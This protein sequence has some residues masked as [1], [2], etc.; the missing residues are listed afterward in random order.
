MSLVLASSD[1][2]RIRVRTTGAVPPGEHEAVFIDDE[3]VPMDEFC[4]MVKE[5]VGGNMALQA[6]PYV[7]DFLNPVWAF[8]LGTV[9]GFT[10]S[11]SDFYEMVKYVLT[12]TD[13]YVPLDPR[14]TLYK[15]LCEQENSGRDED[16]DAFLND[17][18]EGGAVFGYNE[19]ATRLLI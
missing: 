8:S 2:P 1:P 10:I 3:A 19:G 18:R 13:I 12:N 9:G 4:T 7:I 5:L 16:R 11:T 17:C 15:W 6:G 14:P